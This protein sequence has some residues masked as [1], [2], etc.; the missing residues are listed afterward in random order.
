ML[1]TRPRGSEPGRLCVE[2]VDLTTLARGGSLMSFRNAVWIW[3]ILAVFNRK[4]DIYTEKSHMGVA[5]SHG[6]VSSWQRPS[7]YHP[8]GL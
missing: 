6:E 1:R 5:G 2:A 4:V 8:L 7:E 3:C